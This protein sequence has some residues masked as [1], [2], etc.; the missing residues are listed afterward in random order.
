VSNNKA[1]AN[2]D[3]LKYA[4]SRVE[5]IKRDISKKRDELR[6]AVY[7]VTSIIESMDESIEGLEE[8]K[9]NFDRAVESLS[10][11]L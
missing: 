7:E 10:Q 5:I 3:K 1:K 9:R 2:I 8:G 4:L 6:E 11:Y